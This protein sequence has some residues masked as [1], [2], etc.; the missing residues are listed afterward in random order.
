M[1]AITPWPFA[2]TPLTHMSK[3][4]S[5]LEKQLGREGH[6]L[7]TIRS[8]MKQAQRHAYRPE[9]QPRPKLMPHHLERATKRGDQQ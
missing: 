1:V 8:V 6:D 7:R 3:Q 9:P 5:A 2:I 4:R